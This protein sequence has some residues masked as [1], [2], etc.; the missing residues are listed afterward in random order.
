MAVV[1]THMDTTYTDI[2]ERIR[3]DSPVKFI[4]RRPLGRGDRQVERLVVADTAGRQFEVLTTPDSDPTVGLRSGDRYHISSLLCADPDGAAGTV[5]RECPGCGGSLRRGRVLDT[6]DPAVA[7]A[8]SQLGLDEPFGILDS[9]AAIRSVRA[10]S[11]PV[12]DWI[13]AGDS[14]VGFPDCVCRGC[15]RCVE[16][17]PEDGIT[18]GTTRPGPTVWSPDDSSLVQEGPAGTAV[19][20]GNVANGYTPHPAAV[21]VRTLLSEHCSDAGVRAGSLGL[22]TLRCGAATGDHPVT[23]E[24]ERYLSVGLESTLGSRS[25]ERPDLDL[26]VVLDVSGSMGCAAGQCYQ[27][28]P[29]TADATTKLEAAVRG[30]CAVTARLRDDDRLGVV[31]CNSRARVAKPL[32][33][34]DDTE[35]SALR[36]HVQDIEA[37]GGTGIADGLGR[38]F[39]LLGQ[40]AR[41]CTR[42]RR[43]VVL[44]DAIAN[45][46]QTDPAALTDTVADAAA[47][48]LHTTVVGVGLD[49]NAALAQRVRRVRGGQF[50]L[51]PPEAIEQHLRERFDSLVAPVVYDMTLK[52]DADRYELETAHG[53]TATPHGFVYA[54]TLFS[55]VTNG[56]TRCGPVVLCLTGQGTGSDP[57]LALSWTERG[58]QERTESVTVETP[59]GTGTWTDEGVQTAAALCRYTRALRRWAC[60]RHR[61]VETG[62]ADDE[63]DRHARRPVPLGVSKHQ[64]RRFSRLRADLA[65]ARPDDSTLGREVSLLDALC[66]VAKPDERRS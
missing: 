5:D 54:G 33:R 7:D 45:T 18:S 6:V 59:N 63:H 40:T 52:L 30:L 2:C 16:R 38:A 9:E 53:A 1:L 36:R 27:D 41:R 32:R 20:R 50:L 28:G 8:I 3:L 64:V 43:V 37:R 29:G 61:A 55:T 26:V 24:T 21:D 51:L 44:T 49:A 17:Q 62:G 4:T 42:E 15:G 14:V 46:G 34:T 23:G 31:L 56:V 58:G 65:A 19:V 35:L 10:E 22:F 11:T 39:G 12:D 47:Q 25:P 48:G 60:D 13:P 57:G 66:R